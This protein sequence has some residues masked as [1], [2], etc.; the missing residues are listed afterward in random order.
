MAVVAANDNG[1]GWVLGAD[2]MALNDGAHAVL[3]ELKENVVQVGGDVGKGKARRRIHP[4][5]WRVAQRAFAHHGRILTEHSNQ[6]GTGWG[7]A[8]QVSAMTAMMVGSRCAH[9][10]LGRQPLSVKCVG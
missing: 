7:G 10:W 9:T 2:T 1:E 6:V 3:E 8:A 4:H 5:F